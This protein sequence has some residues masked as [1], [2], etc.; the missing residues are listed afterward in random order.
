MYGSTMGRLEVFTQRGGSQEVVWFLEGDQGNAWSPASVLIE[1]DT[2]VD[3][4]QIIASA[5]CYAFN[6]VLSEIF[7]K[8][9]LAL[10]STESIHLE[11]LD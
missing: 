10:M 11:L 9:G 6:L 2:A 8:N 3:Q 4:V 1:L 7:V 5:S